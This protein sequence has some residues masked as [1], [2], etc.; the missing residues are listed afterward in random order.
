MFLSEC[1]TSGD[2]YRGAT[3]SLRGRR[4]RGLVLSR[5]A[6]RLYVSQPAVSKHVA[7]LEAELGAQLI[8][9]DRRGATLTPAGAGAGRL[10]APR[11]GAAREC[12]PR[13]RRWRRRADRDALA[14]CVG[15]SGHLPRLP[16]LLARFHER[17]PGASSSTVRLSTSGGSLEL[18][19]LARGRARRRRRDDRAA[20]ARERAAGRGRCRAR[21]GL[22]RW[23][24]EGCGRRIS[25][26]LTWVS[27]E[28]GSAT[29]A[30]VEAARWQIGLHAVRTLELPSWEAVKLAVANGAGIAAISSFAPGLELEVERSSSSRCRAGGCRGRCL[31]D[32][33]GRPADAFPRS[34]SSGFYGNGSARPRSRDPKSKLPA[35]N[36]E[37]ASRHEH[38]SDHAAS[39]GAR[40]PASLGTA[41][42]SCGLWRSPLAR[43]LRDR[44]VIGVEREWRARP[45][46]HVQKSYLP[47]AWRSMPARKLSFT[48]VFMVGSS[49]PVAKSPT[50]WHSKYRNASV[51]VHVDRR[52][53]RGNQREPMVREPS[54]SRARTN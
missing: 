5:A 9:R 52:L 48:I 26:G 37:S 54:L 33:A 14:R 38:D 3:S 1:I 45:S 22:R 30:A 34:A 18:G 50:S 17:A 31:V 41:I 16:V 39:S 2:E 23:A 53:V 12:A 15:N 19:P 29:R 28:E 25:K 7:S 20:G 8:V 35:Q 27:R 4:P 46:G 47:P 10:R 44:E 36:P 49:V 24:D 43:P 13:A 51:T 21:R 11:G 40:A 42:D 6:E 32:G